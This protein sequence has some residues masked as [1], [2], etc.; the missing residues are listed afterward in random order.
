MASVVD[1]F[2]GAGGLTHGF[3]RQGFNVVAGID[4]DID[5]KFPYEQNN[6]TKFIH[7]SICDIEPQE[8][9]ALFLP[10]QPKILVGCAPCQ[11]F[12]SYTYKHEY[13]DKWDLVIKFAEL[14]AAIKPD[15][16]SM[17][18][19]PSLVTYKGGSV[20]NEFIEMLDPHYRNDIWRKIVHTPNYGVPQIRKRLVVLG[21]RLGPIRLLEKTCD[22]S[23]YATVDETIGSLSPI[24]AGEVCKYDPLHRSQGLSQLNLKRIRQSKPGGTWRDWDE[25]LVAP[26]HRKATGKSYASVYGRMKADCPSPTITTQAYGFG[27]GRFGH[28]SQDRALSLREM[29]LLQTFPN[30]YEFVDFENSDCS[31]NR[32]G[33]LIGN[34]VPVLLAERIAESIERHLEAHGY[35]K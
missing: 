5:C 4:N 11:P 23:E 21:S 9:N 33:R 10:N 31:F 29:A 13:Q 15:V 16:F 17:E 25:E 22:P 24:V 18:N 7:K 35:S 30:D 1:I 3:V 34:A 6:D 27:T 12:S 26:C 8:I 20:F 2:C 19:V 14:I 32:V 28:P